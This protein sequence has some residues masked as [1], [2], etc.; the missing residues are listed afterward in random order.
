M[1]FPEIH[2]IQEDP[3]GSWGRSVAGRNRLLERC[4]PATRVS[5]RSSVPSNRSVLFAFRWPGRSSGPANRL[6]LC[7]PRWFFRRI[8]RTGSDFRS[9]GS[10]WFRIATPGGGSAPSPAEAGSV[11]MG[12]RPKPSSPPVPLRRPPARFLRSRL[13]RAVIR[14]PGSPVPVP[15]AS[16]TEISGASVSPARSAATPRFLWTLLRGPRRCGR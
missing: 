5:P 14:F 1:E 16:E 8:R 9:S 12:L 3:S 11:P 4:P 13:R 10:K 7:T 6:T 15:V 2:G